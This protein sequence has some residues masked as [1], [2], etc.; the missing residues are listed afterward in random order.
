MNYHESPFLQQANL[1]VECLPI[2]FQE[3]CFSLKGGTAI[4]LFMTN[5]PR[6][7]V[8]IDLV[9]LPIEPFSESQEKISEALNRIAKQLTAAIPRSKSQLSLSENKL[10][11]KI[12]FQAGRIGVVIEPNLV[13]RGTLEKVESMPLCEVAEDLF[14]K[15]VIVPVLTKNETC[16]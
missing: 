10:T 2:V 8:D 11:Q 16:W 13:I 1:M 3:S 15:S 5:L 9:Y 12:N 6:L 14:Q 4:N 7:S